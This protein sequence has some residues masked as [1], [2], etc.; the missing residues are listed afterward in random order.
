MTVPLILSK[1]VSSGSITLFLNTPTNTVHSYWR[2]F[3]DAFMRPVFGGR[4][5]IVESV[6]DEEETSDH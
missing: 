5:I 3:D 6:E 4:R 2:K 1:N